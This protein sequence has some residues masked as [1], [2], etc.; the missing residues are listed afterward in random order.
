MVTSIAQKRVVGYIRV[1]TEKTVI[2]R[3]RPRR[4]GSEIPYLLPAITW[5]TSSAMS[6]QDAGMT[7]RST[8]RWFGTSWMNTSMSY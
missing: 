3:L 4:N 7:D 5:L 2:S 6:S 1:S 8:S